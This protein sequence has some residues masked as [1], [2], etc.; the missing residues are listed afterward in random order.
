MFGHRERGHLIPGERPWEGPAR[1]HLDLGLQ[2]PASRT[3]LE[4]PSLW[5]LVSAGLEY[6][7]RAMEI[8]QPW[9][10]GG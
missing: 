2:P 6:A 8:N 7:T 1:P 4:P 10:E 9:S 5:N 3:V